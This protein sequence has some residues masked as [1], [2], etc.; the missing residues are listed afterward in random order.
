VCLKGNP[1]KILFKKI[2]Y[3]ACRPVCREVSLVRFLGTGVLLSM[4]MAWLTPA[5]GRAENVMRLSSAHLVLAT[6]LH[7]ARV[8]G[9]AAGSSLRFCRSDDALTCSNEGGWE[10][11]WIAFED[12]NGDGIRSR[13]EQI[14]QVGSALPS[15]FM[16]SGDLNGAARLKLCLRDSQ[17]PTC[18][19]DQL[20][21][22]LLSGGSRP[23]RS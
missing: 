19:P 13:G 20:S 11:G 16:L 1:V 22:A 21:L 14:V 17:Q 10:Q 18:R 23:P 2:Y 6:Q 15:A 5:L 4:A 7:N 3:A 9:R 8:N 12:R